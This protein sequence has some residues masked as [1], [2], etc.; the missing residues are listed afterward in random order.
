MHPRGVHVQV[1][2]LSCIVAAAS[3]VAMFRTVGTAAVLLAVVFPEAG[4]G[5]L[6][7][8]G[9]V[10]SLKSNRMM[11]GWLDHVRNMPTHLMQ[12]AREPPDS[13]GEYKFEPRW[14]RQR[15]DHFNR[16]HDGRFWQRYFVYDRFSRH[17]ENHPLFVFC[18]AEQGDIES[19]W[20]QYGFVVELARAQGATILWLE[21]RFFGK[22]LPFGVDEAFESRSG[23]VGLLSIEQSLAD[24]AEIIRQHRADG[25]VLTFGGSLSGTIA[26]LMRIQH[27]TLVDMAYASSAPILGLTGIADQFAWQ[28]RLTDNFAAL[29][30]SDCPALVRRG[31]AAFAK[32]D[33]T[34]LHH[35]LGTCEEEPTDSQLDIVLGQVWSFLDMIGTYVYP[36]GISGIDLACDQMRQASS[37]EE[38]FAKLLGLMPSLTSKDETCMNLTRIESAPSGPADPADLGWLYLA[39]TEVIHPIGA[40]NQTDMFPPYNWTVS[41]LSASCR[42]AW[43]VTPDEDFLRRKLDFHIQGVG[44]LA[45]VLDSPAVPGRVLLSSGEYDPWSA[46]VP[47]EG[48]AEDVIVVQIPGGSHCSDLETPQEYDTRDMVKARANISAV[49]ED[50]IYKVRPQRFLKKRSFGEQAPAADFQGFGR[51]TPYPMQ[52]PVLGAQKTSKHHHLRASAVRE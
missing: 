28:K 21:H 44:S 4:A 40:N 16:Q 50:W 45:Q 7:R 18:G 19:E 5:V 42:S 25:P 32:P 11:R 27:P 37:A 22:S 23:R 33:R 41:G 10:S 2:L 34:K 1:L 24:Y 12:V 46:M 9:A 15:M 26:V 31:F 8:H 30:G 52:V 51:R 20:D 14:F 39:C 29:G 43:N 49:L 47:K 3:G 17:E 36:A 48:W 35:T 13:K 6:S 38:V